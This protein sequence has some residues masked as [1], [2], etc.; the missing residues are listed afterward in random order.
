VLK[1]PANLPIVGDATFQF[2]SQVEV[3]PA[4]RYRRTLVMG[5]LA[6]RALVHVAR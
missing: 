2:G 4:D 3:M 6:R 5:C 1:T